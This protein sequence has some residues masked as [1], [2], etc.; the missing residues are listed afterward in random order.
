MSAEHLPK[1]LRYM[2]DE[3]EFLSDYGI[4]AH[5]PRAPRKSVHAGGEWNV[6]P[7]GLRAGG[8]LDRAYLAATP[9]GAG[10]FGFPV[11]FLLIES[12]QKFHHFFGETCQVEFP[13][14]SGESEDTVGRFRGYLRPL[15]QIFLRD[16]DG[17]RPVFGETG[18]FQNDPHWRDYVPFHEYFHGDTGAR[19]RAPATRP[20]GRAWWR[21]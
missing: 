11:N 20:D 15:S 21:N 14:G 7:R 9:T 18:K 13:T 4:R 6:A 19:G 10:R 1:V 17:R 2:L 5:L 8:I 12:L 3:S 16:R